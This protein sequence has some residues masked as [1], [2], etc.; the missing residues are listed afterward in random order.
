MSMQDHAGRLDARR[1][2][3]AR[4]PSV[5]SRLN[6]PGLLFPV[7]VLVGLELL[8]ILTGFE[9]ESVARPSEV[10]LR[11]GA[12]IANGTVF[13]LTW[14]T[15]SAA[16]G[17]LVLGGFIGLVLGV[18]FGALPITFHALNL[19][20]EV[21]RP[22]P[23]VALLPIALL[24]F[25]FGYKMEISLIAKSAIWPVMI[26]THAAI[27]GLHPRLGE[28]SRLLQL[29]LWER[30]RKIVLPAVVPSVFV[31]F[32]LSMGVAVLVAITV[33]I[34]A[35]PRGLGYAMMRAEET[36]QPALMFGLLFWVGMLGW[37][38]NAGLLALQARFFGRLSPGG[39]S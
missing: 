26:L 16:F 39:A 38:L 32:R 27:G 9:R 8:M 11:L 14:E 1:P 25:G 7:V 2:A 30:V 4:P 13:R 23:S 3:P 19:T 15:L 36:L 6:L 21:I 29:S 33:E 22:I 24:V 37:A 31:G 10:L 18:M 35:N 5:L 34:A 28:V 17:G 20:T 12:E